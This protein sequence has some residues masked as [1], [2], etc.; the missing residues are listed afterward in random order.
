MI[1]E[2]LQLV[3]GGLI[4]SPEKPYSAA[5]SNLIAVNREPLKIKAYVLDYFELSYTKERLFD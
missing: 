3:R 5:S 4:A 2:L 1:V